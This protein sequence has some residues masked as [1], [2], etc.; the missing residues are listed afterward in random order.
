[1]SAPPAAGATAPLTAAASSSSM[2]C[3]ASIFRVD[4]PPDHPAF[5]GHFPGRPLLPGVLLLAEVLEAAAAA[6]ELA[7]IVG[8]AP[9]VGAVKF[10]GPVL[11][12]ARLAI[13]FAASASGLRFDVN[14][15]DGAAERSAA[16]G[17]IERVARPAAAGEADARTR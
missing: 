2:P 16:T 10:L 11:P 6:P 3:A 14:I 4:I 17:Q 5:E 1:M 13:R 9:R 12:G 7:A 8:A 15:V